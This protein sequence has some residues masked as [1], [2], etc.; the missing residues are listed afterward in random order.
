MSVRLVFVGQATFFAACAMHEPAGGVEPHFVDHRGGGDSAGMR[1]ALDALD[2]DVVVVFR[3]ETVAPG[4]FDGLR[5]LTVGYN[6]E[7]LPRTKRP[8]ADLLHRLAELRA[9]DAGQ[10]DR[11]MT[12][13][14]LS[15]GAAATVGPVWRAVPLPVDDRFFVPE[16]HEAAHPPRVAFVGWSTPHRERM[17]VDVKHHFDVLHV[18]GGLHGDALRDFLGRVDVAI[19]L[20]NEPYPTFENRVSLHLAA[21]HLVL[22]EPLSPPH[23]LE[24]GIDFLQFETPG[25]LVELVASVRARDSDHRSVRLRGR[26]K[27]E[28]FRA[29]AVWPRI[30]GDLLTDVRAFGTARRG[31]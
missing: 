7:P 24:P 13:D 2:P 10:Y 21:G 12:F 11:L 29:S 22:S 18:A 26:R 3:P 20:H 16:P 19:N 1:R 23:G 8:H 6:T 5:A 31:R 25:G 28:A 4:T 30:A 14:P 15:A 9:T 27:A 17:L